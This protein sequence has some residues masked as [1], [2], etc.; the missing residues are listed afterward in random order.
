MC[1]LSIFAS[2][3]LI[4]GRIMS[5]TYDTVNSEFEEQQLAA[6]QEGASLTRDIART[7]NRRFEAVTEPFPDGMK[8]A[9][10]ESIWTASLMVPSVG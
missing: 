10:I 6:Q 2:N 3:N 1:R 4:S 5:I 8:R 7:F 9:R